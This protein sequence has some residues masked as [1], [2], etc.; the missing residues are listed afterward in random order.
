MSHKNQ[1]S[2]PHKP[3]ALDCLK[4]PRGYQWLHGIEAGVGRLYQVNFLF[5]EAVSTGP[6]R[7]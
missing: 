6:K 2:C 3:H 4:I 7:K 5:A 1:L